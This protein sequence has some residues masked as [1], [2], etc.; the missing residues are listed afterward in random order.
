MAAALVA[1]YRRD[2]QPASN[3]QPA[4]SSFADLQVTRLTDSGNAERP[5]ISP[6]GQYVAYVQRTGDNASLRIRQTATTND[7]EKVASEPGVTLWGATFTPDA[8][9]IDFVRQPAGAPADVWRVPV[10]GGTHYPP[11]SFGNLRSRL[12]SPLTFRGRNARLIPF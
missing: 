10:L 1:L 8:T 4:T 7:V 12:R 11:I 9:Y 6:D 3:E 2:A 5:A